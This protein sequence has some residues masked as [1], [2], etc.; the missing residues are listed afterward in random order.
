MPP[1]IQTNTTGVNYIIGCMPHPIQQR[2]SSRAVT[3]EAGRD[4]AEPAT[5]TSLTPR[6][7]T[8][9]SAAPTAA[10]YRATPTYGAAGFS[11]KGTA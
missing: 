3:T 8:H 4:V 6:S 5:T 11:A 2:R 1:T 10:P 7:S 9:P